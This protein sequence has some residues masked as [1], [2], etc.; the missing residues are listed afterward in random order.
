MNP[1]KFGKMF[2]FVFD[3]LLNSQRIFKEVT[4]FLPKR[5]ESLPTMRCVR[6]P[7]SPTPGCRPDG[8]RR[9]GTDLVPRRLIPG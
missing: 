4:G 6:S 7:W 1:A 5:L 3:R 8:R 9:P 2:I